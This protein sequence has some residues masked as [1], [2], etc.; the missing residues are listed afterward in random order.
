MRFL[1]DMGV[2]MRIVKW[3]RE[4]GYDDIHLREERLHRM[5]DNAIFEKADIEQRILLTFDLD[6]GEIIAL[7]GGRMVSVVLFRLRN[8]RTFHVMERLKKVLEDSAQ[9][10]EQGAIVV[11]EEG[12]HRIRHLPLGA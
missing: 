6:F 2:D 12:R 10:L 8:T 7:S 11:V 9:I 3:L 5:S 1:A 4:R